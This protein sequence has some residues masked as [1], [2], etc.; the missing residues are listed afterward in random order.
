LVAGIAV[1]HRNK[2]HLKTQGG[3]FGRQ[4]SGAQVA[5]VGVRAKSNH[6]HRRRHLPENRCDGEQQQH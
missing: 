4:T 6:P 5:V 2:L 3:I 1:G